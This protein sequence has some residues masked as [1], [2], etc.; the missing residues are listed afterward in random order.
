M[1]WIYIIHSEMIS[2]VKLINISSPH[3]WPFYCVYDE[4]TWNLLLFSKFQIFNTLLLIHC[5]LCLMFI[6]IQVFMAYLLEGRELGNSLTGSWTFLPQ[7]DNCTPQG[8]NAQD[9][10]SLGYLH[11]EH[12]TVIITNR[13][14][15]SINLK[16]QLFCMWI[17]YLTTLCGSSQW[18]SVLV[19]TWIFLLE[20]QLV[21]IFNN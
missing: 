21:R 4:G 12:K 17:S 7:S 1:D 5:L 19:F 10:V 13:M 16:F 15:S 11:Y 2:R 20:C 14:Y 6:S 3:M 8:V 9:L 18:L